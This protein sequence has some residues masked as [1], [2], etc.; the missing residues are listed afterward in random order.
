MC[1]VLH[2][3]AESCL[4]YKRRL[5]TYNFTIF[6]LSTHAG[7]C[8]VW[9]ETIAS[10]G[11][12]EIASCLFSYVSKTGNKNLIMYSDNCCA[13]N[14]N[15]YFVI[16]LWYCL[17]KFKMVSITQKY[18]EKGHTFNE[19]DSI[20][21]TVERASKYCKIYT[22]A[23]WAARVRSARPTK[24]YNVNELNLQD[25]FDFKELA[26]KFRNFDQNTEGEKVYWNSIRTL[27]FRSD[28]P[29]Q[30]NC[31]TEFDGPIHTVDLL[32]KLRS[33]NLKWFHSS[34]PNYVWVKFRLQGQSIWI[35][36]DCAIRI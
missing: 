10:R 6:D 7:H 9:N 5:N 22:T 30:F 18:L 26:E 28:A 24:P 34:W 3:L 2:S 4:Y 35:F 14:K 11:A 32:H 19:G 29:D 12:C 20:H 21:S 23:Q 1:V 13:Q 36:L 33:K 16:I 15:R 27:S 31:Q 25:F 17:Q 8:Y